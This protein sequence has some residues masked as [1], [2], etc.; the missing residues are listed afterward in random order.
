MKIG[1][2]FV[3]WLVVGLV[4]ALVTAACGDDEGEE[5]AEGAFDLPAGAVDAEGVPEL[6]DGTLTVLSDIAYAPIEFYEDGDVPAGLDID[7]GKAVAQVLG[8]DVEFVNTGFDGIIPALQASRGDVIWSAMTVTEERSQEIDFIPYFIAGTGIL[9]QAG[10]PEGIASE[11]DLCGKAVAVQSGTIQFDQLNALNET[12]PQPIE[13]LA[14]DQNPLAVEQLRLGRAVAVLADFPVAAS[15][16]LLSE[17]ELEVL[18]TQIEPAPYGIGT[19]K[20]STE[21]ARVIREALKIV[22]D[23]G[24]YDEILANWQLEAGRFV[25]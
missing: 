14:F 7:L 22:I 13:V 1:R 11:S 16:A 23:E 8:V 19:R 6:E 4:L 10:N 21:L 5:A 25:E 2:A 15:D 18:D 3:P 24:V 12:C 17:G 20:E 9:I